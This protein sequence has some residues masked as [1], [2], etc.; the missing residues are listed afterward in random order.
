M[1]R[2]QDMFRLD[3]KVAIIT[4]ASKGIGLSIAQ[5]LAEYGAKVVVS[6]RNQSAVE[7]SAAGIRQQGYEATGLACHVGRADDLKNLVNQT[8]QIYGRIDILVNNAATN[9]VYGPINEATHELFE[10]VM[11][12]NVKGPF[13]LSN[14]V[15]PMMLKNKGGSIIHISSVEGLK[16]GLGLGVYSTTKASLIMLAQNQA[17]EW[18]K[19]G[20]RSNVICPGLIR[21][22]FSQALWTNEQL[23][24]YIH[25]QLPMKRIAE[26]DEMV[27]LAV[28]LASDASSYCTG[29][30]YLA[31]GG[32]M[33]I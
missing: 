1:G 3:G 4:G 18:G 13:V 30:I 29:S 9:P 6:S 32:F 10:K 5:A 33:L 7:E 24:G 12:I 16:P 15:Y 23:M 27:G 8:M 19:D 25:Q 14:L 28:F 20:I 31:D 11:D 22:K 21:T 17:K 2:Y 26:P